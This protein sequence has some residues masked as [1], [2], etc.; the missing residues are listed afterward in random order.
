[1]N[2]KKTICFSLPCYNEKD[3]VV[4]LAESIMSICQ[5]E[6]PDYN[7]ILQFIDNCSTDGT[8]GLLEGLCAKYSQIRVIFNARNFPLTS[9]FYGILQTEGDCTIAIPTDF[10][11][12]LDVIPQLIKKWEAGAKIVCLIKESTQ[13]KKIMWNIRQLFY[14]L[15]QKFSDSKVIP[16]YNGAGLYDKQFLDICRKINDPVASLAQMVSTLGWNV[17][18]LAYKEHKRRHGKSKNNFFTLFDIAILRF[19][20]SSNLGPRI[21]TLGGFFLSILSLVIGIIYFILK[22]LYWEQFPVGIFP[23]IFGV[24]FIGGAQLFFTGLVGEYV[25]KVNTRIMN[26]PLVVEEKRLGFDNNCEEESGKGNL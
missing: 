12:P 20:N 16:N 24:F 17:E 7:Y 15:S 2:Q 18:E 19:T 5:K 22:L 10:Q 6:L 26:R 1:M 11:V 8:K 14:K 9:G 23:L 21:A 13:E 25:I 4:P 3:N